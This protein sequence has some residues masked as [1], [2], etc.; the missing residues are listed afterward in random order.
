MVIIGYKFYFSFTIR[1]YHSHIIPAFKRQLSDGEAKE[2]R[3]KR[4]GRIIIK[5]N[6]CN[7][8]DN[9]KILTIIN[10]GA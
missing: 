7:I 5:R 2:K 3:R 6:R 1:P 9:K 4:G 8:I 10:K